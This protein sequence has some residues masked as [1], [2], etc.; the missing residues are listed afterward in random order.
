MLLFHMQPHLHQKIMA[1][2]DF[3]FLPTQT[4]R[5]T[6]TKKKKESEKEGY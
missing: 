2:N 3:V 4:H 6:H 5:I 1:Q